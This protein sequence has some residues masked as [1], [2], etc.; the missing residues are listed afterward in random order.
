MNIL[1]TGA[2][3]GY[4]QY[5]LSFL[6]EMKGDDVNLFGLVRDKE[7]AKLLE[8]NGISARIG[9]FTDK[10]SLV[11]AFEG[12]DRLLFVSV[13]VPNIQRNVV[14]AIRESNIQYVAYTSIFGID[15]PR[16]GLET[17]HRDTEARLATLNIPVT[18]LRNNWYL[19]IAAPELKAALETGVHYDS[20]NGGKIAWVLKRDLA[21][22][23]ARIMLNPS[24]QKSL[25]LAGQPV[26]YVQLVEALSQATGRQIANY[27]VSAG[28][29]PSLMGASNISEMGLMLAQGYQNLAASDSLGMES[30]ANP[31]I[32]EEIIGHPLTS[33]VEAVADVISQE[34]IL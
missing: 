34:N 21:E 31:S 24:S 29:L 4:G 30:S 7:K 13:S 27:K 28:E 20:S 10:A 18:F 17:I 5:A 1:V 22:A 32:I 14:E 19:E 9:D 25:D 23:G 26:T 16:F 11:K 15:Y 12:I 33:L 3:G 6:K 2:T 8:E